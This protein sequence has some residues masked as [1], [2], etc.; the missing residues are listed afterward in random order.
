MKVKASFV[1]PVNQPRHNK[2]NN[3]PSLS[4]AAASQKYPLTVPPL[5]MS[6]SPRIP[7]PLVHASL[8]STPPIVRAGGGEGHRPRITPTVFPFT[9]QRLFTTEFR[10][11]VRLAKARQHD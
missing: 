3:P 7:R 4:S 10:Q 8:I 11:D 1:S 5:A 2:R 9:D 6:H